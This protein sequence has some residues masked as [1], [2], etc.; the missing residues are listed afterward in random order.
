MMLTK[1]C[2]LTGRDH[3]MYI[4]MTPAYFQDAVDAWKG[5]L[6]IQDAFPN[7]TPGEREFIKTG[8]TPKVWKETF[9]ED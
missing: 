7:L 8:I 4:P 1:N 3:T 9:G 5:G 2:M 6:L